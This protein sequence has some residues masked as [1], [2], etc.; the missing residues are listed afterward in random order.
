MKGRCEFKI[1]FISNVVKFVSKVNEKSLEHI[2]KQYHSLCLTSC[3]ILEDIVV[4][5]IFQ[6]PAANNNN[7]VYLLQLL[8][9]TRRVEFFSFSP[10]IMDVTVLHHQLQVLCYTETA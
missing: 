8:M 6:H 3:T 2:C 1:G 7:P 10:I 9:R 5:N 4:M